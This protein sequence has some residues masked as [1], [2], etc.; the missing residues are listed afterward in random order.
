MSFIQLLQYSMECVL[1]ECHQ[2]VCVCVCVPSRDEGLVLHLDPL[3]R[4][5][6]PHTALDVTYELRHT[7]PGH[8]RLKGLGQIGVVKAKILYGKGSTTSLDMVYFINQNFLSLIHLYESVLCT[9]TNLLGCKQ[10]QM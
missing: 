1:L 3:S 5:L 9:A 2:T 10:R 7:T 4:T 6:L 8:R